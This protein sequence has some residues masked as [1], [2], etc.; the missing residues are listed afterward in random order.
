M[1]TTHQDEKNLSRI[2]QRI[3]HDANNERGYQKEYE[4]YGYRQ[5]LPKL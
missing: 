1:P 2:H 4:A 5:I 3:V